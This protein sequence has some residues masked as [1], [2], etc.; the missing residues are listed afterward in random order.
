M[1]IAHHRKFTE[2]DPSPIIFLPN[3]TENCIFPMRYK[4][5]KRKEYH[6][7]TPDLSF[8]DWRSINFCEYIF[9]R[10]LLQTSLGLET[11][12]VIAPFKAALMRSGQALMIEVTLEEQW[13]AGRSRSSTMWCGQLS[14]MS[15]CT[16]TQKAAEVTGSG[17]FS[18]PGSSL[19][20]ARDELFSAPLH[21][22]YDTHLFC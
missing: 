16:L 15:I 14:S 22:L 4:W 3:S 1:S 18:H 12:P 19:V 5:R 2:H 9:R 17:A 21:S 10:V 20:S 8:S 13:D 7:C 11:V 6:P